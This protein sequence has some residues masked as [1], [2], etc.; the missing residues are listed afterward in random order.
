MPT[1]TFSI[2][3]LFVLVNHMSLCTM[4]G[5]VAE[6]VRLFIPPFVCAVQQDKS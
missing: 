4:S 1:T 3:M 6:I 5:N 2:G